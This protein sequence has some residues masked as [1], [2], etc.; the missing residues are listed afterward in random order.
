MSLFFPRDIKESLI[1]LGK[2][3]IS[4]KKPFFPREVSD[5]S[6]KNTF[7]KKKNQLHGRG[8]NP[9][10]Y[11]R[12]YRGLLFFSHAALEDKYEMLPTY[13]PRDELKFIP[14]AVIVRSIPPSGWTEVHPS[15]G[16]C[17]FILIFDAAR[18]KN[19]KALLFPRCEIYIF[20]RTIENRTFFGHPWK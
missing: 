15:G 5:S 3:T 19:K 4:K 20:P 1:S 10:R 17:H 16:I 7:R 6:S 18:E 14:R 12:K 9:I 13:C 11:L 8:K 2:K